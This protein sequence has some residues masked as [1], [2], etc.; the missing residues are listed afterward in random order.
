KTPAAAPAT[1]PD[2]AEPLG[3]AR[4]WLGALLTTVAGYVDAVGYLA[5]GGLFAPFMSGASIL[6]GVSAG[7]GR[8]W[9][10]AEGAALIAVF[11]AGAVS[12]TVAA[13]L[14]GA[15]ALP[16]VLALEAGLLAGS[17][18]LT[19]A[20]HAD[21]VAILP[22]VAAMGVQNTALRPVDGVRLGVTYMTGTLVSLGQGIGRMLTGRGSAWAWSP[23]ALLWVGFC[24][25][26]A[27]G[28]IVYVPFGFLAVA[29]P[30]AV[31]AAATVAVAIKVSVSRR[32]A[33][34]AGGAQDSGGRKA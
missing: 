14:T 2:P 1:D 18:F 23:H 5:L 24:A 27:A 21:A 12:A 22:I 16:V 7:G 17:A 8:W 9:A 19:H 29:G 30:A 11:L 20:G 28:G 3:R 25:G 15:W 32:V 26:A 34:G 4:L 6:L 33:R 13:V 10:V 31:V